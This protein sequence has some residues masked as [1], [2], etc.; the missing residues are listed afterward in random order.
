MSY[1]FPLPIPTLTT[2][3][4]ILREPREADFAA[5]LEFNDSARAVFLGGGAPRQQVWRALLS[6]I[7]HWALRGYGF[8]SVDTKA[9]VFIGRVG[10]I[11][12]DGWLE[13]ELAWHLFEGFEGQGYAEEAALASRDW[14]AGQA[15]MGPLVSMI[16]PEN[17]RSIALA[18]RLGARLEST[19]PGDGKPFHIFRHP[20]GR[21]A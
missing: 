1:T 15:D 6:N 8:W 14:A 5:M 3:R 18:N 9:G 11:Y 19:D 7:G 2:E 13:P 10:V 4:L 21:I 16:D 12:H 20:L 17:H